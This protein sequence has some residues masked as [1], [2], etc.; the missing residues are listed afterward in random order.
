MSNKSYKTKKK[1][2]VRIERISEGMACVLIYSSET[3]SKKGFPDNVTFDQ[4]L[5]VKH[6]AIQL[7]V[8]RTLQGEAPVSAKT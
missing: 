2:R 8:G 3:E 7:S 6:L 5:E 4:K 1:S